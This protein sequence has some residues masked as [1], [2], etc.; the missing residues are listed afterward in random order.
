MELPLN[1]PIAQLVGRYLLGVLSSLFVLALVAGW[2][3]IKRLPAL[4]LSVRGANWPT[5]EGKVETVGVKMFV[6][7]S[8]AEIGYS[9]LVEGE[10]HAGYFMRQF[11]EEQDAWSYAIPLRGQSVVV[12]YKAG[13][14]SLSVLRV[15]DQ[16]PVFRPSRGSFTGGLLRVFFQNLKN[17]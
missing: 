2:F 8:I 16:S 10:R 9:F 3:L 6:E 4:I 5:A 1:N 11:A 7:Q 12:R 13:A 17:S 15:D 14:P